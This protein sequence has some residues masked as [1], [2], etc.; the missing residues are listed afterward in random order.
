MANYLA[1]A[2]ATYLRRPLPPP[3]LRYH[4]KSVAL[5]FR[6]LVHVCVFPV[7]AMF[8]PRQLLSLIR[9]EQVDD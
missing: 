5:E 4:V 8:V 6:P 9:V 1:I 7:S 2:I 3:P